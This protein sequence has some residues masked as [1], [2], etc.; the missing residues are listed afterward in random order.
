MATE[1]LDYAIQPFSGTDVVALVLGIAALHCLTIRYRDQEPGM[2]WITAGLAGLA[3]WVGTN[4]LHLPSGPALNPSPWYYLSLAA[5]VCMARGLVD[6]LGVPARQRLG[7]LAAVVLPA[8]AFAATVA[9]VGLSGAQVPRVAVHGLT[10]VVY[11]SLGLAALGA[12]R[13]EPGAGHRWLAAVLLAVP[14][15]VLSLALTGADAVVLRYGALLPLML[16]GLTLPTVSLLRRQRLLQAEVAL[17]RQAEQ[18]LAALN[19]SLEAQVAH[20]TADLQSMVAGLESFNRSV[21]HDLQGPLGGIAGLA[22]LAEEAL[23]NG[24]AQVARRALPVIARQADTSGELVASLLDLARVGDAQLARQPVDP[25]RIAQEVIAQLHQ[26][27]GVARLPVFDVKPLPMVDADPALLRAVL[28]NLIGNAVKFSQTRSDARVEI[29]VGLALGQVCLQVR[30]NGV[31]FDP[32][33]ARTVFDPFSRLHGSQFAGH[34]VGLSIVRRAVERHGGKVWAESRPG[35]GACF[36][37][38]LPAAA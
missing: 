31:G 26:K 6:Y 16:V 1:P 28:S 7:L 21:S 18:A 38:T 24:D 17:R 9:W 22:R 35:Q 25:A 33:S 5:T 34:G 23:A 14:G 29:D 10:A 27:P 2:G 36:S 30:D 13:R 37:F 12:S 3:L 32:A 11:I 4:R 15:L 19:A 8:C 20:R